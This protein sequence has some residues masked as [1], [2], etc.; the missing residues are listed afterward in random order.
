MG[1][2]LGFFLGCSILSLIELIYFMFETCANSLRNRLQTRN[3]KAVG[4]NKIFLY[5][6]LFVRFVSYKND[7][8]LLNFRK[9]YPVN[10]GI[11]DNIK[12]VQKNSKNSIT[13]PMQMYDKEAIRN[14]EKF[15]Y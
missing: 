15:Y 3:S 7:N 1:G 9:P 14:Y 13:N 5:I 6:L 4:N 2:V 12:L 11:L 8:F 10:V